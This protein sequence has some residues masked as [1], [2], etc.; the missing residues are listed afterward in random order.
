MRIRHKVF[1]FFNSDNFLHLRRIH[2]KAFDRIFLGRVF[3]GEMYLHLIENKIPKATTRYKKIDRKEVALPPRLI[4]GA[5][6][7]TTLFLFEALFHKYACCYRVISQH[8]QEEISAEV[9]Q[10]QQDL[11]LK[12]CQLC[13]RWKSVLRICGWQIYLVCYHW[14]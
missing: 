3:I 2:L 4:F 5:R 6:E 7:I 12:A 9:H 14:N 1:F 8:A 10:T 13:C 11:L